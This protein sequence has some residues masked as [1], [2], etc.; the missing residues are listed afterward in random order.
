MIQQALKPEENEFFAENELVH[1]VPTFNSAALHFASGQYGPFR[2]A[3]PASVPLWL[4]V[5]MKKLNQCRVQIPAWLDYEYLGKV[6]VEEEEA[7]NTFSDALPYYY[8]EIS[9]SLFTN[10]PDEF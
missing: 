3:R 2:A 10:C 7:V 5:Y 1:I 8:Y 6:K 4:A 9:F